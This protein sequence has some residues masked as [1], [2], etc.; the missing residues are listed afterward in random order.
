MNIT[1]E[2][3]K[4]RK[5]VLERDNYTCRRCGFCALVGI[6]ESK[7]DVHHTIPR[8]RSFDDS[9]KNL[10]CLCDKCHRTAENSYKKYGLTNYQRKW[11]EENEN[12][13]SKDA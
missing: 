9:P 12:E 13:T 10:I 3:N 6:N 7:L 4:I 1:N 2:W 8:K 11:I 5:I